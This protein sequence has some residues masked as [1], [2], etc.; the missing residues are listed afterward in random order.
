MREH[1]TQIINEWNP[2][3]IYPL[4]A[5][6]YSIEV[7]KVLEMLDLTTTVDELAHQLF[8]VFT[9]YFEEDFSK[10]VN[11]CTVIAQKIIDLKVKKNELKE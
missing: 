11:D 2:I 6:E 10:S 4:L 1:I 8:H 9:V 5:D 3:D 7:Q